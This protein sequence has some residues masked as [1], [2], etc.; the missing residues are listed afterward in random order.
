[1]NYKYGSYT[2]NQISQLKQKMRKQIYFLLLI[3]DPETKKD[4]ENIDVSQTYNNTMVYFAGLNE[5]LNEPVE[6]VRI[7]ALLESAQ[8]EYNSPKFCYKKYR[9]LILDAGSEVLK[10]KE[11]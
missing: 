10:I 6:L 5:L 3:V 2:I 1:M 7:M 4:Y 8:L 11:V 9:K